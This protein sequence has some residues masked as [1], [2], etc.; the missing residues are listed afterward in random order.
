VSP[1]AALAVESRIVGVRFGGS[2]A[3][4]RSALAEA[5]GSLSVARG[6]IGD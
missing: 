1:T 5:G 6:I 2:A 3:A 4:Y